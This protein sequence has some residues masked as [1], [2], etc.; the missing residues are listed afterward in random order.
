MQL[1][2]FS[3]SKQ[4]INSWNNTISKQAI[5]IYPKNILELK[6][7]LIILKKKKAK[8]LIRTGSCSYDSKSINP[9][10]KTYV[11]SLKKINKIIKINYKKRTLQVEAGALI[12][13]VVLTLKEKKFTLFSVP[14]GEN[15]SIGGAI[16]ANTIGKDSSPQISSFGD[17]VVSL[18]IITSIGQVK[19]IK[20]DNI[21]KYIGA[22]GMEGIILSAEIKIRKIESS[23]LFASS[24]ILKSFNEIKIELEK[25]YDYHY[26]QVDPFFRHE[27]LAIS[28]KG[29][30]INENKKNYKNINLKSNNFEKFVFKFFGL[31]IN[32]LTW[33][34]F[35]KFFFLFNKKKGE[36]IDIHNFHY[37]SKYKHL[38]PLVCTQGLLDYELLLKKNFL[39][40]MKVLVNFLRKK[41]IF[42]MYVIIKKIYK[43]KKKFS[44]QFNDNGYAVAI[45][46]NKSL[47][48]PEILKSFKFFLKK[49]KFKINLSKTDEKFINIKKNN[50]YL[51]L[52]L[53]KK[54][55]LNQNGISRKRA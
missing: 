42:P 45:S 9:D 46:I 14:G 7:L 6:K 35:Y 20:N 19:I 13:D 4:L 2:N 24:K 23:N 32:S 26:I 43:S 54:M 41:K 12:S 39:T 8:Y 30:I 16:S 3:S 5:I 15:I 50:N 11:I 29:K 22:F 52:S 18:K 47:V 10:L 21:L 33:K 27:H 1:K 17:A 40:S 31:F 36:T 53:Y 38:I 55:L 51:F 34:F 44:Y 49:N 28:F 48:K 25:N 37:S